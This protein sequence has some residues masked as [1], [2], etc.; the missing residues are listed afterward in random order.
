MHRLAERYLAQTTLT[1][2]GRGGIGRCDCSAWAVPSRGNGRASASLPGY[3]RAGA[4]RVAR[5]PL[6]PAAPLHP[7]FFESRVSLVTQFPGSAAQVPQ[8]GLKNATVPEV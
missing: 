8:D 7:F 1:S 2:A 6:P 4:V 3:R 5:T